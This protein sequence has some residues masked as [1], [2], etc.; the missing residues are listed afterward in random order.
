VLVYES[1]L[2]VSFLYILLTDHRVNSVWDQPTAASYRDRRGIVRKHTFD[3]MAFHHD[4]RRIAYAVKPDSKIEQSG[5]KETI[6]LIEKQCVP[7]FAHEIRL[8]TEREITPT[9]AY[10]AKLIFRTRAMRNLLGDAIDRVLA[11][12]ETLQGAARIGDI[13]RATGL[14]DQA[15]RALV[16]LIDDGFVTADP[17]TRLGESTL[18]CKALKRAA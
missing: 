5:I 13:V 2:E 8:R 15:F 3:F 17:D 18:V 12:T 11:I 6:S 7:H 4:G 16:L 10:N 1:R 14:E 9:R